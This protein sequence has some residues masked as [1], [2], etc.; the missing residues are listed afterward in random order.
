MSC[1]FCVNVAL[2]KISSFTYSRSR[3]F[4]AVETTSQK[5]IRVRNSLCEPP[6][7][8]LGRFLTFLKHPKP[9]Q[10][11]CPSPLLLAAR[12]ALPHLPSASCPACALHPL[13]HA[14]RHPLRHA[15]AGHR[16][17]RDAALH[18]LGQVVDCRVGPRLRPVEAS[19]GA[20]ERPSS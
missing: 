12:F 19:M 1:S 6:P 17:L 15:A 3:R 2:R 18:H 16:T 5:L 7:P 11:H 14:L 13:R 8:S 4:M 10:I 9:G 20:A